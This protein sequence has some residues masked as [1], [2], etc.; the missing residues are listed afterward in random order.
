MKKAYYETIYRLIFNTSRY[1]DWAKLCK[2][3]AVSIPYMK[4]IA[5]TEYGYDYNELPDD[6]TELCELLSKPRPQIF[7]ELSE[8]REVILY[9]PGSRLVVPEGPWPKLQPPEIQVN[10]P[11]D[12]TEIEEACQ[13][14]ATPR[15]LLVFY[16]NRLGLDLRDGEEKVSICRKLKAHLDILRG[17]KELLK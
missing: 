5:A 10:T 1:L 12:W 9:Q 11:A 13:N 8:Q 3:K 7:D 6:Q 2:S 4:Y 16:A 15:G 17:A 14:V